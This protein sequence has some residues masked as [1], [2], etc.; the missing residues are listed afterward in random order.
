VAL[1]LLGQASF[2]G[3]T[4]MATTNDVTGDEIKTG[5]DNNDN[6]RNNYDRIFRNKPLTQDQQDAMD[7]MAGIWN[8]S[9]STDKDEK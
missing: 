6:Y 5:L 8:D 9:Y 2:C 1:S 7:E 3:A 4:D